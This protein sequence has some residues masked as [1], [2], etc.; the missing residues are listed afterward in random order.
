MRTAY[1]VRLVSLILLSMLVGPRALATPIAPGDGQQSAHL[2]G[3]E[4]TVFTYRPDC[5]DRGMLLV[6]HGINRDADKYRDHARSLGDRLCCPSP[7]AIGVANAR[8]PT[9]I[10]SKMRATRRTL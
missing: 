6:L 5:A 4:L 8:G 3:L 7:G 2:P 10:E 1:N 9:N